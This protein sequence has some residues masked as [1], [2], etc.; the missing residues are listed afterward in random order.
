MT[1]LGI[2]INGNG[3]SDRCRIR[4]RHDTPN[5][6]GSTLCIPLKVKTLVICELDTVIANY[7]IFLLSEIF[8]LSSADGDTTY[9]VSYVNVAGCI[10]KGFSVSKQKLLYVLE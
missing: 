2:F 3:F 5:F 10:R 4:N 1:S 9:E 6:R 7:K 8:P